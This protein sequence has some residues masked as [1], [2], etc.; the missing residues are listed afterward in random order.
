MNRQVIVGLAIGLALVLVALL[1]ALHVGNNNPLYLD[2]VRIAV[3][4]SRVR[5]QLGDPVETALIPPFF[6]GFRGAQD[7]PGPNSRGRTV[8]KPSTAYLDT[9][10]HGSRAKGQLEVDAHEDAP[11]RWSYQKL[12]LVLDDGTV[13]ELPRR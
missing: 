11:G 2:A 8:W 1:F 5:A 6:S 13:I 10:L 3:G 12:R 9:E 4:N 7:E